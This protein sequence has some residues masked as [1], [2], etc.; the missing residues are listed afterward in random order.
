MKTAT[1]LALGVVLGIFIA[2]SFPILAES[3]DAVVVFLVAL[4]M[5]L[6]FV[7]A[8]VFVIYPWFVKRAKHHFRLGEG[9]FRDILE[10]A[11][12]SPDNF[13][14]DVWPK[15]VNAAPAIFLWWSRFGLAAAVVGLLL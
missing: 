4:A 7:L 10:Y 13:R 8:S 14:T 11:K 1:I 12:Q 9:S 3:G 6:V 5:F 15:V 2:F